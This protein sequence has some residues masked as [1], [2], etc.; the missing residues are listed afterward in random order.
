MLAGL[1]GWGRS[2]AK[3]V[4]SINPCPEVY[5]TR[6]MCVTLPYIGIY[7]ACMHKCNLYSNSY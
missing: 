4:S 3:E 5:H 1:G 7:P 6:G 2:A